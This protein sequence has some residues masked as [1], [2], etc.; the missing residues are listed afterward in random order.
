VTILSSESIDLE[1]ARGEVYAFFAALLLNQPAPELLAGILSDQGASA[2]EAL[3]PYQLG[4]HQFRQLVNGYRCGAWQAEDFVLDY[5]AMFRVPG[6]AYIHPFES[7]YRG[8]NTGTG[9]AKCS[10]VCGT[11]ARETVKMYEAEGLGL[12]EGFTELPDHL[13]VE[14]EFMA[15]LCR[16]TA[17]AL[18]SGDQEGAAA[19]CSKQHAFLTGHILPWSQGCLAKMEENAN[20]PLY[21]CL[22]SLLRSFLEDEKSRWLNSEMTDGSGWAS[23]GR[24]AISSGAWGG[25]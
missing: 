19:F 8:E 3:F 11:W 14:L 17:E 5:D 21:R 24:D 1:S 20:T 10:T 7:V 15:F 9:K 16:K 2:L 22:A 6:D 23:T 18:E 4:A 25:A 12:R 13:G